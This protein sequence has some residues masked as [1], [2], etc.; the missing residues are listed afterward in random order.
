MTKRPHVPVDVQADA[1]RTA[2]PRYLFSVLPRP[3]ERP[4][5]EVVGQDG[6]SPY[7]LISDD[8]SEI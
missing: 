8:A 1:P 5:F 7:C 4:R 3:G 6:G 2:F